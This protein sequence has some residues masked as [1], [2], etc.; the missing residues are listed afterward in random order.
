[1]ALEN[2]THYLPLHQQGTFMDVEPCFGDRLSFSYSV[3]DRSVTE[4]RQDAE[5][6]LAVMLNLI[7]SALGQHWAPDEV[8]FTHPRPAEGINRHETIFGAPIYFEQ[9]CNRLVFSRSLLDRPMLR[10][11]PLLFQ[12]I[13]AEFKKLETV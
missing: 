10:Q 3:I 1:Q 6:S 5:L 12:L 4:R 9:D 13:L 8:H 11:D 7:R 2:F